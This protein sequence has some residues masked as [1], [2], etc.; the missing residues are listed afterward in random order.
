MEASQARRNAS[1]MRI[2][3]RM[4]LVRGQ[5][6]RAKTR[7]REE[8]GRKIQVSA[9]RRSEVELY[10]ARRVQQILDSI[11]AAAWRA[12]PDGFTEHI[13]KR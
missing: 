4:R 10:D 9:L 1:G 2:A 8:S 3:M 11:P 12:R 13:N 6:R 5:R 7:S